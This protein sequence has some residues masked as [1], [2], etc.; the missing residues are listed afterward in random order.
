MVD[1]NAGLNFLLPRKAFWFRITCHITLQC[2]LVEQVGHSSLTWALPCY[3]LW[4]MESD[5]I[6]FGRRLSWCFHDRACPGLLSSAR[7]WARPSQPLVPEWET[8]R[9]SLNSTQSLTL[10]HLP[11]HRPMSKKLIFVALINHWDLGVVYSPELAL[12]NLT[13][14]VTSKYNELCNSGSPWWN[15]KCKKKKN[16]PSINP[17]RHFLDFVKT[18]IKQNRGLFPK[19]NV[20]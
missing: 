16:L 3:L 18:L 7:K 20:I 4:L 1:W 11:T 5:Q 9:E 6:C 12:R 10:S 17:G 14:I 13:N 8:R 15:L 2:L 19:G